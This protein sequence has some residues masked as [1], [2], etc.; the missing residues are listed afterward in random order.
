MVNRVFKPARVTA[1]V[2]PCGTLLGVSV[3][4]VHAVSGRHIQ[5]QHG[6]IGMHR[7]QRPFLQHGLVDQRSHGLHFRRWLRVRCCCLSRERSSDGMN[8]GCF[9]DA[10]PATTACSALLG[11]AYGSRCIS[12]SNGNCRACA[13]GTWS[14][15]FN[16][17]VCN[18]CATGVATPGTHS[19]SAS[20]CNTCDQCEFLRD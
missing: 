19:T 1:L 7:L 10:R 20:Q 4:R 9:T 14:S 12:C 17:S 13:I 5:W 11:C 3:F 16:P 18:S 6:A 15:T 2:Q 8:F